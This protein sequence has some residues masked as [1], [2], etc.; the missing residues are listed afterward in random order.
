M[1]ITCFC[2]LE[3]GLLTI[4]LALNL[5]I[6]IQRVIGLNPKVIKN[7]NKVSGFVDISSFCKRK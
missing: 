3:S 4:K 6:K 5:G 1:N 7:F 2:T